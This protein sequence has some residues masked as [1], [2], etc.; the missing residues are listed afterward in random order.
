MELQPIP[1]LQI[2][3]KKVK[4]VTD[5][6]PLVCGELHIARVFALSRIAHYKQQYKLIKCKIYVENFSCNCPFKNLPPTSRK[7]WATAGQQITVPREKAPRVAEQGQTVRS[8][9]IFRERR[10]FLFTSKYVC[11]LALN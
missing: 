6:T 7:G 4:T 5:L 11:I 8:V 1:H 3:R 10:P 9:H 2:E